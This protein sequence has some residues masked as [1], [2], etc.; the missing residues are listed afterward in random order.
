MHSGDWAGYPQEISSDSEGAFLS[1]QFQRMVQRTGVGTHRP[2]FRTR[3]GIN[4]TAQLDSAIGKYKNTMRR[5]RGADRDWY[6]YVGSTALAYNERRHLGLHMSTPD[7][8]ADAGL[9]D[10]GA[11]VG[12]LQQQEKEADNLQK[13]QAWAD[14]KKAQVEESM[15]FRKPNQGL[16]TE[17]VEARARVS[18][19][20]KE[21]A[22]SEEHT[23]ELQSLV[24]AVCRLGLGKKEW[25]DRRP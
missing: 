13:S 11:A 9:D 6:M 22:R 25:V 20:T 3:E 15:H 16:W 17:S 5:L 19:T 10:E 7:Q 2:K 12:A 18:Q 14:K 21:K 23:S 4:A 24:N 8:V 1:Q